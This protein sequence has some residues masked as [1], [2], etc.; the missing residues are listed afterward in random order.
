MLFRSIGKPKSVPV[1][2]K[3]GRLPI[4]LESFQHT[5]NKGLSLQWAGPGFTA[6]YLSATTAAG[7]DLADL[8]Q[9]GGRRRNMQDLLRKRGAEILGN[10]RFEQVKALQKELDTLKRTKPWNEFTLCVTEHGKNA[11]ETFILGRGNPQSRGDKVAP[12][13]LT[14]L[15][16]GAPDLVAHT[17]EANSSGRRLAFANW[18]TDPEHRLTTR[19]MANRLWQHHFGRGIVRSP[20]NFGQLGDPPTHPELLDWLARELVR[21]GWRLKALHKTMLL[22]NTYRQSS[23]GSEQAIAK[24]PAND[25]FGRFNL[26]RVGAEE[27]RDSVL[28]ASG[29]FN[30]KMF[31]P[32]IYIDLSQEVLAG[33]SVPGDRKSTRLNS[34]H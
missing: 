21:G 9:S 19:V 32:G 30:P 22:S 7:L 15:G 31:G 3:Q 18:A 16:G 27:L 25:W 4:R 23:V 1:E 11:P 8:R 17:T 28:V 5:A 12:A 13:F 6:R 2:L 33:Q 29:T 10:E 20:N 34:S 26:R 14:A 24:D